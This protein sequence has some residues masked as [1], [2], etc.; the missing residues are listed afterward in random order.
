MNNLKKNYH[1]ISMENILDRKKLNFNEIS[2]IIIYF[3]FFSFLGFCFESI[4]GIFSKGVLESRKSFLFGPFCAIYGIGAILMIY[5]LKNHKENNIKIFIGS[6]LIGAFSEYFMSYLCE[7]FLHFKWWDYRDLILN[8]HGRTCLFFIIIWGFLGTVLIKYI[9]PALDNNIKK[10]KK[11][12]SKELYN[13]AIIGLTLF[14]VADIALTTY[15]LRYLYSKIAHDYSL[16]NSNYS[17]ASSFSTTSI[18]N[19]SNLLK[20]FPNIRIAGSKMDNVFVDSL[21]KVSHTYY[22]KFFDK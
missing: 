18:F 15:A 16:S 7:I 6:A 21:Y 3:T 10:I 5:L 4:F 17:V 8:I 22:I 19:E 11:V 14:F 20:I 13:L 2:K 12:I 9:N 1:N